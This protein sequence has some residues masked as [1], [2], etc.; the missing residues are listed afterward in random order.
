MPMVRTF[1]ALC[2]PADLLRSL[3]ALQARLRC[4]PGGE[5]G[6]W[7][8]TANMHLTLKFFGDLP[9][10]QLPT[11]H[12]A[13]QRACS[14]QEPFALE[15]ASLGCF[16]NSRLPRV[17]WAGL[18]GEDERLREMQQAIERETARAGFPP[19]ERPFHP[20]LTLARARKTAS[21]PQV[22]ALGRTVAMTETGPLGSF[23][24]RSVSI[25][26]S[27][28]GPQGPVYTAMHEVMLAESR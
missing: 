2:L 13:I 26:R 18:S 14:G 11:L 5:A 16:P 28:P 12:Q 7:A 24:V 23:D 9:T 27:D 15:V 22:E 3:T 25:M 19:E 4:Q 1:A 17:V 21:R 10:E 20:H 6:R 8:P